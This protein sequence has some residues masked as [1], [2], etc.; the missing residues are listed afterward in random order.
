MVGG[1]NAE[2][3]TQDTQVLQGMKNYAVTLTRKWLLAFTDT[4]AEFHHYPML[5]NPREG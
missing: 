4:R 5:A 2:W 1:L 3:G